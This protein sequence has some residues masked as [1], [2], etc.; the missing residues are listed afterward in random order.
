MTRRH[1]V[2]ESIHAQD[3]P[4]KARLS[5]FR[6]Y[7]ASYRRALCEFLFSERAAFFGADAFDGLNHF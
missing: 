5:I 3:P 2:D 6:L 4:N 7:E 1:F